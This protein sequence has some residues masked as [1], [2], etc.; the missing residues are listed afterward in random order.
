MDDVA[1]NSSADE[2]WASYVAALIGTGSQTSNVKK[3][4]LKRNLKDSAKT[5]VQ[6][7]IILNNL[8][9]KVCPNTYKM[10]FV[11][12]TEDILVGP[13]FKCHRGKESDAGVK[14]EVDDGKSELGDPRLLKWKTWL[15]KRLERL[16][17]ESTV[18]QKLAS[19]TPSINAPAISLAPSSSHAPMEGQIH[20]PQE[21]QMEVDG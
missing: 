12:D 3:A 19:T 15:K 14:M 20:A 17:A 6:K 18:D 9:I 11:P 7:P 13:G 10:C 16:E 21:G 5:L 8:E 4:Y 1:S 2:T